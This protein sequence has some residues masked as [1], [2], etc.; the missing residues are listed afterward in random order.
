MTD[1]TTLC[2]TIVPGDADGQRANKI[3]ERVVTS[4]YEAC[5]SQKRELE[6]FPDFGPLTAELRNLSSGEGRVDSGETFKVTTCLPGGALVIRPQFFDQFK[7]VDEFEELVKCH[8]DR[9]NKENLTLADTEQAPPPVEESSKG[10]TATVQTENPLT[11]EFVTSLPNPPG[12]YKHALTYY[13][14]IENL[15]AAIYFFSFCFLLCM[16]LSVI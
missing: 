1:K 13:K 11:M 16:L 14:R 7:D 15:V 5:R 2:A 9:F 10:R 4:C 8:N 3:M 6:G 12:A